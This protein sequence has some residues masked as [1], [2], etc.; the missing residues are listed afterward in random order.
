MGAKSQVVSWP[1]QADRAWLLG[2]AIVGIRV[3]P[4]GKVK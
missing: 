1:S 4:I 3:T 2:Y